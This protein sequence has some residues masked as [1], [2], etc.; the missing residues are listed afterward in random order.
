[1]Q[2]MFLNLHD[3]EDIEKR[4]FILE[5]LLKEFGDVAIEARKVFDRFKMLV[6]CVD[7]ISALEKLDKTKPKNGGGNQNTNTF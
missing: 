1:M 2:Q 7:V 6:L 5:T 4:D 3:I